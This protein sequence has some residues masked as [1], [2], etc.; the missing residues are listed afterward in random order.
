M[1]YATLKFQLGNDFSAAHLH[2]IIKTK[3]MS[4]TFI[5]P[6]AGTLEVIWYLNVKGAHGKY[7]QVVLAQ[8][9]VTFTNT[10]KTTVKLKL[11][12]KGIQVL[13]NRKRM[14]LKGKATFTIPHQQPVAWAEGFVLTH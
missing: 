14:S 9:K 3:S 13:K 6:A 12:A 8:A 5:P 7:K 4:L 2:T 10:K 11:T 1:I